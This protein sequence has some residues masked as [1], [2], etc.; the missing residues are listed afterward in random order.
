MAEPGDAGHLSINERATLQLQAH[1]GEYQT[2]TNR[3]TY[4]ISLQYA[5]YGFAAASLGFVAGAWGHI[6]IQYQAW[7]CMLILLFLL[8][9]LNQTIF[10]MYAIVVYLETSLKRQLTAILGDSIFWDYEAFMVGRRRDKFVSYEQTL[11]LMPTFAIGI[12]AAGFFIVQDLRSNWRIHWESSAIWLVC[13]LYVGAMTCLKWRATVHLQKRVAEHLHDRADVILKD[14]A[15]R[16]APGQ[17]RRTIAP[18]AKNSERR[19]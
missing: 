14:E 3:I 18:G 19:K 2:L 13:C 10:E 1:L 11:G 6:D 7:A 5:V 17:P 16:T 15:H 8:W 4:W 9:A 12:L